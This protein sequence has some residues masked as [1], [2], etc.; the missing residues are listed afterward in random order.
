MTGFSDFLEEKLIKAAFGAQ[1]YTGPASIYAALF[2]RAPADDGT[3]G[4]EVYGVGYA[5]QPVTFGFVRAE[6]GRWTAYSAGMLVFPTAGIGG[7]GTVSY[8]GLFDAATNGVMLGAAPLTDPLTGYLTAKTYFI[9]QGDV[10]R[11]PAA[12][13][14][15]ALD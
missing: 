9:Q 8:F 6:D 15:A 5:R 11:I 14:Q 12:A 13:L 7:W 1:A 2:L 4:T 3:G 10:L